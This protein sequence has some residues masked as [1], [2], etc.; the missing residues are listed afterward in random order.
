MRATSDRR[1]ATH[2][3]RYRGDPGARVQQKRHDYIGSGP[4][5]ICERCGARVAK[6]RPKHAPGGGKAKPW[7][8]CA[9]A[10]PVASDRDALPLITKAEA[11]QFHAVTYVQVARRFHVSETTVRGLRYFPEPV[12]RLLRDGAGA[13]SLLFDV[14][15]VELAI[16]NE[17]PKW[18]RVEAER[19]FA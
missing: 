18:V 2:R 8:I 19:R 15:E 1:R 3:T 14:I 12:A 10:L 13:P 5:F 9:D 16:R 7:T 4:A 6:I 17:R 11:R